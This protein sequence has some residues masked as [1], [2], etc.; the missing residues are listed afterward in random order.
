MIDNNVLAGE[1]IIIYPIHAQTLSAGKIGEWVMPM[2]KDINYKIQRRKM[3]ESIISTVENKIKKMR[4]A[5]RS[6]TS[7]FPVFDK[8]KRVS[9]KD[10]NFNICW[11]L[12]SCL[13]Q[14][15]FYRDTVFEAATQISFTISQSAFGR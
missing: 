4:P 11:K 10:N 13:F 9:N 8:L 1:T 2:P 14:F 12:V 6:N 3:V 7:I 5:V 15:S